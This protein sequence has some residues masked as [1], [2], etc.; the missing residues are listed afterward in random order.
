MH[1]TAARSVTIV[2]A[3]L[4]GAPTAHAVCNIRV[5]RTT[6]PDGTVTESI[7]TDGCGDS[8]NKVVLSG[9]SWNR[10]S[11]SSTDTHGGDLGTPY[12]PGANIG[13]TG[14]LGPE[15]GGGGGGGDSSEPSKKPDQHPSLD[16]KTAS[17]KGHGKGSELL[18]DET[19]FIFSVQP[20]F[21][22]GQQAPDISNTTLRLR[23]SKT[24][25]QR[26]SIIHCESQVL[27]ETIPIDNT[28]IV[29]VYSSDRSPG[30]LANN[31]IQVPITGDVVPPDLDQV[32]LQLR[33]GPWETD[34]VFSTKKSQRF[35]YKW[36]GLNEA[37]L[38]P[39]QGIPASLVIGYRSRTALQMPDDAKAALLDQTLL[40]PGTLAGGPWVTRQT[41]WSGR[42]GAWDARTLGLGGWTIAGYH[43]WDPV[44]GEILLGEGGTL[45]LLTDPHCYDDGF[46]SCE[47]RIPSEDG[48]TL[49]LF[50]RNRLHVQ[51]K[52]AVTGAVL[53]SFVHTTIAGKPRLSS[54]IQ[55]SGLETASLTYVGDTVASIFNNTVGHGLRGVNLGYRNSYLSSVTNA[56]GDT[57]GVSHD[58]SGMLTK[59][60]DARAQEHTF[61]Y[62]CDGLLIRDTAPPPWGGSKQL[63]ASGSSYSRDVVVTTALGRKTIYH[64]EVTPFD[65]VV[66]L[67]RSITLPDGSV[68]QLE[69]QRDG[70]LIE[71][72]ADGSTTRVE[73]LAD[74]RFGDWVSVPTRMTETT[75]GGRTRTTDMSITYRFGLAPADPNFDPTFILG[76]TETSTIVAGANKRTATRTFDAATATTTSTSPGGRTSIEHRDGQGVLTQ[77]DV[78]DTLST[79]FS[80]FA[81]GGLQDVAQGSRHLTQTYSPKGD[82]ST[83][84]LNSPAAA[85]QTITLSNQDAI[86]RPQQITTQA[87]NA[88]VYGYEANGLVSTV[89]MPDGTS[90]HSYSYDG[91]NR[92]RAYTPPPAGV[93]PGTSNYLRDADGAPG[94]YQPLG[95]ANLQ[96]SYRTDGLFSGF[97]VLAADSYTSDGI[98]SSTA[99]DGP[100]SSVSEVWP[101]RGFGIEF[102][103]DDLRLKTITWDAG[104]AGAK[105]P[106][107]TVSYK[108]GDL[109]DL[110]ELTVAG[111]TVTYDGDDDGLVT[112]AGRLTVSRKASSGR[113][114][115]DDIVSSDGTLA[116]TVTHAYDT[117]FGE[118]TGFTAT[119]SGKTLFSD[120]VNVG[121]L[122]RIDS[123]V[124][125]PDSAAAKS[126]Y[127][128]GYDGDGRLKTVTQDKKLIASY[129]YDQ[130]GNRT[131]ANAGGVEVKT[132]NISYDAQD[133]LRKYGDWSFDYY[134]NGELKSRT[135]G[136]STTKYIYSLASQLVEVNLPTGT[137]VNYLLDPMGRRI[138][139]QV[140]GKTVQ[141]FLYQGDRVAAELDGA[142]TLVSRFVYGTNALIPDYMTKGGHTYRIVSDH[143][144]S[145]RLIVDVDD[146]TIAQELAF[147]EFGNVLSDSKAG[148][149]PFGFAAGIMDR[150][151]GLTHFGL[152]EYDPAVGRWISKDATLQAGGIN[153]YSYVHGDPVSLI[154]VDGHTPIPA[155]G[156]FIADMPAAISSLLQPGT[157]WLHSAPG[158]AAG[159][160]KETGGLITTA[161]EVAEHFRTVLPRGGVGQ[162]LGCYTQ[163][164]AD[165]VQQI[166]GSGYRILG[167]TNVAYAQIAPR[168]V[169]DGINQGRRVA[170]F[171][172]DEGRNVLLSTLTLWGSIKFFVSNAGSY[173]AAGLTALSSIRI[174]FPIIVDMRTLNCGG[175]DCPDL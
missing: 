166:L 98:V 159:F 86:G 171:R 165:R 95:S 48:A 105:A 144:G 112:R 132:A 109:H 108:F 17:S 25:P 153:L 106:L 118:A 122:L 110:Q 83:V 45:K 43:S 72:N 163:T 135:N 154:D 68:T 62:D 97:A 89:T 28:Q 172:T 67:R 33:V 2:L 168:F 7:V 169:V 10:G 162:I 161:E 94:F 46:G 21:G 63:E 57:I 53:T 30:F 81:D 78:P 75:P 146:G 65:P 59:L 173:A 40:A 11:A 41:H 151:T 157:V 127:E 96:Y 155:N 107:G 104:S 131:Y 60:T 175:R 3:V 101:Y 88:T 150:D 64:T 80:Y 87:G 23:P 152:R 9:D 24:C 100:A 77:I 56:A 27:Q 42:L 117:K 58:T 121:P 35:N 138:A 32:H 129:D 74:P 124:E 49:Y 50:D 31:S 39:P 128:Y 140:D 156:W 145:P 52:D 134:S 71:A 16:G 22:P 61:D 5:V 167:T 90:L 160:N 120:H 6:A 99:H 114:D 158:V 12:F 102:E 70:T 139:K 19:A 126:V 116:L 174:P 148:F 113:V 164:L 91:E 44:V 4:A 130:N 26:G 54:I 18:I 79:T 111:D 13:S 66:A 136:T 147:D 85:S 125:Q 38:R 37:G 123:R 115:R 20:T 170:G 69:A 141:Q 29:L 149:Q 47:Y 36:S 93:G 51:T 143:L 15:G 133:R 76:A 92:L 103:Y 73:R 142:G 55:G 84:S 82:L 34:R 14:T 137:T 119:Q 1:R 8:G